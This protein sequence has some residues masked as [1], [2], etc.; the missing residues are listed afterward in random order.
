VDVRR[1]GQVWNGTRGALLRFGTHR[2]TEIRGGT[3]TFGKD[4]YTR[5][6]PD[7]AGPGAGK[8]AA[9][10]L[11]E[12]QTWFTTKGGNASLAQA[13]FVEDASFVKLREL[14]LAYTLGQRWV[15]RGLGFSSVDL[16]LAG[17]NLMTWT[18][19]RG[20]DPESNLGGAEYL[21]QGVDY[22]NNPQTRSFVLAATFNR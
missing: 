7:V 20:L 18:D 3:A 19:Y 12:W 17:R 10:T 13:Q 6:Y 11:G 5:E 21:T 15:R 22:F 4:F 16:R 9:S 1:G 2:D 8:P 14:S